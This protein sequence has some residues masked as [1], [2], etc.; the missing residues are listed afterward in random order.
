MLSIL[1]VKQWQAVICDHCQGDGER[2]QPYMGVNKQWFDLKKNLGLVGSMSCTFLQF[3]NFMSK[4]EGNETNQVCTAKPV[5][6]PLHSVLVYSR[7]EPI[8]R[9]LTPSLRWTA[10]SHWALH[11][12]TSI[13]VYKTMPEES[14]SL[15]GKERDGKFKVQTVC[16]RPR[17][18]LDI[19]AFIRRITALSEECLGFESCKITYQ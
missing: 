5:H 19:P 16:V 14:C 9:R 17:R 6:S 13:C 4:Q 12:P 7:N 8:T 15:Q 18:H 3:N 2:V 10:K 1:V 11:W